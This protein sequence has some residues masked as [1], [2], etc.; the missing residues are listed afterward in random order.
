M[1]WTEYF[2]I[3]FKKPDEDE[4]IKNLRTRKQKFEDGITRCYSRLET[5]EICTSN[6]KLDDAILLMNVL[7]L[8]IYNLLLLHSEENPAKE[9]ETDSVISEKIKDSNLLTPYLEFHKN[10]SLADTSE[11]NILK[12][13]SL[14]S[15]LLYKIEKIAKPAY[16]NPVDNF[17][18]RMKVQ[19]V[20]IILLIII[21]GASGFKKYLDQR[22]L[23]NDTISLNTTDKKDIPPSAETEISLPLN[24]EIGWETVKFQLSPPRDMEMLQI[25]PIHQNRARMQFKDLKLSDDKGNILFQKDLKIENLDITYL[26]TFLKTEEIY[27]GKVEVGRALEVESTGTNPKIFITFEKKFEKVSQIEFTI[28]ATKRVNQFKE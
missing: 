8:D 28:R 27:P 7:H 15:E 20:V 3:N 25:N 17:R 13:E 23:T 19:S 5:I 21:A 6:S 1:K 16:E 18:N 14:F 26:L 2:K 12:N 4:E 11:D 24:T 22:P 9:V 10:F